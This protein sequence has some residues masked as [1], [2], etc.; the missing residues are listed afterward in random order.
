MGALS[1]RLLVLL[2]FEPRCFHDDVP[3]SDAGT[4]I[5]SSDPPLYQGCKS[6]ENS[7]CIMYTDVFKSS[8]SSNYTVLLIVQ[9]H[10]IYSYGITFNILVTRA[11]SLCTT[12]LIQY[13]NH[14]NDHG[15]SLWISTSYPKEILHIWPGQHPLPCIHCLALAFRHRGQAESRP[16]FWGAGSDQWIVQLRCYVCPT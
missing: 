7:M 14:S 9:P 4:Q 15:S 16:L 11:H 10:D 12:I 8:W 5:V 1:T 13:Y 2:W 3:C 6:L